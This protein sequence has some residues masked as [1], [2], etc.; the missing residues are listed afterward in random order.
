MEE[1]AVL[2][3]LL[4]VG[5]FLCGG[6]APW[7]SGVDLLP[8]P[9]SQPCGAVVHGFPFAASR[10]MAAPASTLFVQKAGEVQIDDGDNRWCRPSV[11]G[12]RR[13]PVRSGVL[14]IQGLKSMSGGAPPTAPRL[15]TKSSFFRVWTVISFFMWTLL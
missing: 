3:A 4:Q 1:E 12:D 11:A 6:G 8:H 15:K 7:S 2:V 14:L 10:G 9:C 13:L 5:V